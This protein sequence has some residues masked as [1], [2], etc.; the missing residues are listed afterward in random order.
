[1][2]KKSRI[3]SIVLLAACVIIFVLI[4]NRKKEHT[5]TDQDTAFAISNE[6]EIQKIYMADLANNEVLLEKDDT[7]VWHVNGKYE[8]RKDHVKMLLSTLRKIR[9]RNPISKAS[10]NNVVKD[11]ATSNTRVEVYDKAGR[12]IRSFLVGS[13]SPDSKGNYMKLEESDFV[14]VVHIPG[15]DGHLG[16]RFFL[17]ENEWRSRRI[18]STAIEDL[19]KV[20]VNYPES[21]E[22]SFVI[23]KASR[24]EIEIRSLSKTVHQ[25]QA[26][27]RELAAYLHHYSSIHAEAFVNHLPNKDSILAQEPYAVIA[28]T[29]LEGKT[30]EIKLYHKKTGKRTKQQYDDAGNPLIYDNERSYALINDGQDLVLVQQFVFGKLIRPYS[31]FASRANEHKSPP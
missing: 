12:L 13:L 22:Q 7:D 16:S 6:A 30:N 4:P 3:Y 9:V 11:M 29:D 15:F 21:V 25:I 2:S 26:D 20:Q 27:L 19:A 31:S 10:H 5:F 23:T 28:V 8:A 18:F 24:D 1:M 17:E 14:F